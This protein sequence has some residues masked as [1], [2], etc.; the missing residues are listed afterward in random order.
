MPCDRRPDCGCLPSEPCKEQTTEFSLARLRDVN[1]RIEAEAHATITS[2]LAQT[3]IPNPDL[4][5]AGILVRCTDKG[6]EFRYVGVSDTLAKLNGRSIDEHLGSTLR[7]VLGED[8]G[9]TAQ[10][11]MESVWRGEKMVDRIVMG[12]GVGDSDVENWVATYELLTT[13]DTGEPLAVVV[14]LR[15]ARDL[16]KGGSDVG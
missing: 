11:L 9:G 16:A 13:S 14:L 4:A 10:D 2:R 12:R 6:E 3:S 8:L 15:D 1:R 7:Q 5:G